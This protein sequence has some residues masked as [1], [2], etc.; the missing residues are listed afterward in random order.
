MSSHGKSQQERGLCQDHL[1]SLFT[2]C[3][4]FN[5]FLRLIRPTHDDDNAQLDSQ[6]P[7]LRG[8]IVLSLPSVRVMTLPS[9]LFV[10]LFVC[11]FLF[12]LFLFL[13]LFYL[14]KRW[15]PSRILLGALNRRPRFLLLANII[16]WWITVTFRLRCSDSMRNFGY[17][18][19]TKPR[20]E[21]E[22]IKRD[23]RSA[24]WRI[25]IL[26]RYLTT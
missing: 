8:A 23:N 17:R 21:I 7:V 26:K 9:R 4:A 14:F 1:Q 5:F 19:S 24:V 22:M 12:I 10:C 2:I 15:T 20:H 6:L 25:T 16:E 18:Y 11:L 13:F 3:M